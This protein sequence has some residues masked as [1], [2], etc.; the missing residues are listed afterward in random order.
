MEKPIIPI[1]NVAASLSPSG[2][3]H[4]VGRIECTET[5]K[6]FVAYGR[7][8]DKKKLMQVDSICHEHHA[9]INYFT[10]C[11]SGYQAEARD[12]LM[13]HIAD[14]V[15]RY[16][17]QIQAIAGHLTAAGAQQYP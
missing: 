17:Q 4:T 14:R 1:Y 9:S 3:I 8:I 2:W 12:L 10:Y 7:R 6:S 13:G 5:H 11:R 16:L 15:N